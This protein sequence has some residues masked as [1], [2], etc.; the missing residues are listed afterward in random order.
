MS[1]S[2]FRYYALPTDDLIS[3]TSPVMAGSDEDED[4]PSSNWLH[5][6]PSRPAKL[7]TTTGSW[8]FDFLAPQSLA[9]IAILAHNFTVG[10][11]LVEWWTSLF[12]SPAD[13]STSIS[14]PAATDDG[15]TTNA[16]LKL[17]V[18]VTARYVRIA[19]D[20]TNTDPLSLGRPV[21]LSALRDLENDV[22]WSVA[23]EGD[24]RII[25]NVTDGDDEEIADIFAP[26]R[27][28]NGEFALKDDKAS[29]LLTLH[30]S[31]RNRAR[32]FFLAPNPDSTDPE[33]AA[34]LF[35]FTDTKWSRTLEGPDH[36]IFPF[37]VQELARGLDWP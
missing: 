14:I 23:V 18:P 4:Y 15:F 12:G 24:H 34:G 22:R 3:Y 19:I 9:A 10:T 31:A 27:S 29:E 16:F 8:L 26:R 37:R 7:T 36:N 32:P 30:R 6:R 20:E 11:V 2:V 35:R 25:E 28:F 21:F 1:I 17:P 33:F 5:V 13:G